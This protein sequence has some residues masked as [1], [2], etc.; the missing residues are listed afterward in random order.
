MMRLYRE[1]ASSAARIQPA[2]SAPRDAF[3]VVEHEFEGGPY[4]RRRMTGLACTD[5]LHV[6]P[7]DDVT[8]TRLVDGPAAAPCLGT[9]RY[10]RAYDCLRTLERVHVYRWH[11]ASA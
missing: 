6:V 9:Y 2:P 4:D 1:H 8:T 5:D 11:E 10:L 7:S 3:L